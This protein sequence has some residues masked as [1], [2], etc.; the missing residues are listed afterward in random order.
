MEWGGAELFRATGER[1][2]L[3]EAKRYAQMAATETWMGRQQ[4]KHYQF[5]PFMNVGHFRLYDL[6][7]ADLQKVLAG[8]YREGIA[9]CV[10]AGQTSPFR[11]GVPFIWCSNNL[12]VALVTQCHFYERMTGDTRFRGFAARN[13]DWLLGRNPWGYS[14]FTNV[15]SVFPKDVHLQTTKLTSRSVPGGL[16]DGPVSE[17]IFRSQ[18]G[19]SITEPD[20]LAP[21]QD[22]RAVYHDDFKDYVTNEPTMDGTASAILMFVAGVE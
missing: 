21:F 6:V 5:Y 14:M 13:R 12:V 18:L 7:D 16:V 10:R 4:A 11:V 19:V 1:R 2:Y 17:R 9:R 8:Y 3:D 22:Q 15:A 20:P